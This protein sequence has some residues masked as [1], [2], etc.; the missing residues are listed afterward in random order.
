[1]QLMS[2]AAGLGALVVGIVVVVWAADVL[3]DGLLGIGFHHGRDVFVNHMVRI[4][5]YTREAWRRSNLETALVDPPPE[6]QQASSDQSTDAGANPEVL[7]T[8]I[9]GAHNTAVI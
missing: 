8:R 1:M 2:T 6:H 3:V 7:R 4:E 5:Q 9:G